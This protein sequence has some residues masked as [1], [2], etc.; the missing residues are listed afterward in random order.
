MFVD[1]NVWFKVIVEFLFIVFFLLRELREEIL[2]NIFLLNGFC[3]I[4]DRWILYFIKICM[5]SLC[6]LV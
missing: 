2:L 1:L 4:Y 5:E 6:M 3:L